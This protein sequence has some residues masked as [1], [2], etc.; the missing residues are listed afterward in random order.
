MCG[1]IHKIHRYIHKSNVYSSK[2]LDKCD[3]GKLA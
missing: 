3:Y 1:Y 2:V